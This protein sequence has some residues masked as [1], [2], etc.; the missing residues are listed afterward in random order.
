MDKRVKIFLLEDDLC[1]Y[2]LI[3]EH[4]REK[5]YQVVGC[6]DGEEAYNLLQKEH[7]DIL[8]LDINVPKLK[9]KILKFYQIAFS[10]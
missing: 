6:H 5:G 9:G 1:L 8:L 3:Q 7:V 4:L 10:S 2:E